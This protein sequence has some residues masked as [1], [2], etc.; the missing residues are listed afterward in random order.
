MKI[1]YLLIF[2]I[3]ISCEKNPKPKEILNYKTSITEKGFIKIDSVRIDDAT[4]DYELSFCFKNEK[5]LIYKIRNQDHSIVLKKK[6]TY[7]SDKV[8]Y[9]C[10]E[11]N[12]LTTGLVWNL[13]NDKN[14]NIIYET[15]KY[16]KQALG[17]SINRNRVDFKSLTAIIFSIYNNKS[18]LVN[19]NKIFPIVN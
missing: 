11:L 10:Y 19:L 18:Y 16:D 17:D 8:L 5:N 13:L 12:D 7:E 4:L 2:A 9:D 1:V 6:F 15:E 14:K 3:L